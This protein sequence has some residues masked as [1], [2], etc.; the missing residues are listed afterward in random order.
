[1]GA[2]SSKLGRVGAAG[3]REFNGWWVVSASSA[4]PM[5]G[6][7]IARAAR[8][9]DV[10]REKLEEGNKSP[11]PTGEGVAKVLDNCPGKAT[12]SDPRV[13]YRLPDRPLAMSGGSRRGDRIAISDLSLQ[14]GWSWEI[15]R[16]FDARRVPPV[17]VVSRSL[18]KYSRQVGLTPVCLFE[19]HIL[20]DGAK[21]L[22]RQKNE[23]R[24]RQWRST[25]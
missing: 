5:P 3:R 12:D 21:V 1:L 22:M 25:R 2:G 14:R 18:K 11:T 24:I 8:L 7:G 6:G 20:S 16:G 4:V 23:A 15:D 9:A 13:Q 17:L 19:S 10:S